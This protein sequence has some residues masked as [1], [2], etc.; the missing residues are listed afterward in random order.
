MLQEVA[1]EQNEEGKNGGSGSFL[2]L[3]GEEETPG[4]RLWRG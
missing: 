1:Q 2:E 3:E 4:M